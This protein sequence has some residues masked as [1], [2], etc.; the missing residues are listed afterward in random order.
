MSCSLQSFEVGAVATPI[1]QLKKEMLWEV[2]S[3]PNVP[4][5]SLLVRTPARTWVGSYESKAHELPSRRYCCCDSVL[6]DI[7]WVHSKI[8]ERT[9]GPLVVK[10]LI[11]WIVA[12]SHSKMSIPILIS[13]CSRMWNSDL[14]LEPASPV[15]PWL[16]LWA[17]WQI[18]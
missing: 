8:N 9:R 18:I 7:T 11:K 17:F 5:S 3:F 14:R 2:G 12:H 10:I 15:L 4:K 16:L 1:P 13:D 6:V